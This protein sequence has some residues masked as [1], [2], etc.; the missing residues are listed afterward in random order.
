MNKLLVLGKVLAAIFWGVVLANL[1][2][3]FA[4]PFA[5]LL[6]LAGALLLLIHGLELWAF[7]K[8]LGACQSPG[9]ERVQILLFGIFHLHGLSAAQPVAQEQ[10][11][12]PLEAG[13]A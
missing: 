8:R 13:N 10:D 4:Q 1:L 7:N 3:P 2:Q 9:Q 12:L 6:Q 5:L 11:D